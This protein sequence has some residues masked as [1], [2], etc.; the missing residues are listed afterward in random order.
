MHVLPL[1]FGLAL[2]VLP[3]REAQLLR[4][5]NEPI[6]VYRRPSPS[7]RERLLSDPRCAPCRRPI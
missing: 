6:L 5:K 2:A 3:R 1:P 4:P 7:H